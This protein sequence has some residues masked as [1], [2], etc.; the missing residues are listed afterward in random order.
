MLD[1]VVVYNGN[2][3]F[4]LAGARA[5]EKENGDDGR[6]RPRRRR[7]KRRERRR[8]LGGV[9]DYDDDGNDY[10]ACGSDDHFQSSGDK[11]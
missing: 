8:G 9:D 3:C 4:F 7:P 2:V 6:S 11:G 10:D 1:H 5:A